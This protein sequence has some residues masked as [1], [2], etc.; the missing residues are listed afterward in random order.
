MTELESELLQNVKYLLLDLQGCLELLDLNLHTA[1]GLASSA[2]EA[3]AIVK[4][5]DP[6]WEDPAAYALDNENTDAEE[7]DFLTHSDVSN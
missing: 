1:T 4:R 2:P 5:L 7:Q 6:G 3:L